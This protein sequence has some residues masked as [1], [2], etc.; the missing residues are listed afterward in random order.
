[1]GESEHDESDREDDVDALVGENES[2]EQLSGRDLEN[3]LESEND[4][5][6]LTKTW[7]S[8]SRML[9]SSRSDMIVDDGE[10]GSEYIERRSSKS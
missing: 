10:D 5:D 7:G 6:S 9:E 8:R 1:M 3:R 2:I 4:K